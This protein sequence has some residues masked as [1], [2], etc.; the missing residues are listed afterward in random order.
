MNF[1]G[2]H[3]PSIQNKNRSIPQKITTS[4]V[5]IR[6][7]QETAACRQHSKQSWHFPPSEQQSKLPKKWVVRRESCLAL[8]QYY[9]KV[10]ACIGACCYWPSPHQGMQ[11]E[12]RGSEGVLLFAW[13][14]SLHL[15]T[16][17]HFHHPLLVCLL[18]TLAFLGF[19]RSRLGHGAGCVPMYHGSC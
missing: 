17:P 1:V 15:G 18:G 10:G 14:E 4:A 8:N 9:L 6:S 19:R 5:A 13:R 3:L 11:T 7:H 12:Y 2:S 16:I